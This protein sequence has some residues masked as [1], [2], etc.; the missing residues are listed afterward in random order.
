MALAQEFEPDELQDVKERFFREAE[1]AGRLNHP[2]IVTIFDAGEEH[3]LAYIAMEFLKGKDLVPFTKPDNLL[4]LDRV[5]SIHARVAE[6]LAYA[7]R[8]NVVHR[9]IK[10]ANVM[11]ELESDTVKVTDFGIAR[12]TDSSRTK[13][14]MVLGTP[15]YM[16]PEQLS[17]MK[18][19][20][21]SDLFSLAVSL[22]QMASGRLPFVADSMA[23][24]MFKIANEEAPD[25]RTYNSAIPEALAAV[26]RR[27]MSKNIELR[28]QSGDEMAAELR[29]VFGERPGVG[30]S[31]TAAPLRPAAPPSAP[32]ATPPAAPR[33]A[34]GMDATLVTQPRAPVGDPAMAATMISPAAAPVSAPAAAP[35]EPAPTNQP[36]A[37]AP[38]ALAKTDVLPQPP[39]RPTEG[40]TTHVDFEL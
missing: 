3:D 4:P 33:G 40:G 15:S 9:D 16:S 21:R 1:T 12:I 36:V 8:Q 18:I 2:N 26:I 19:D 39:E 31:A 10:P 37:G 35:R 38:N 5:V 29:A 28:Y 34:P 17:G 32:Q 7:H 11:Y 24:L 30:A 22:F 14:G 6:A 25:P 13:T 20:G 27:G 23:Q